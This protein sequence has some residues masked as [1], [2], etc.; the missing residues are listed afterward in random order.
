MVVSEGYAKTLEFR[1]NQ[2]QQ[3]LESINEL[4]VQLTQAQSTATRRKQT[5]ES[6]ETTMDILMSRH[7]V[8][9]GEQEMSCPDPEQACN[10]LKNLRMKL[11]EERVSISGK[12]G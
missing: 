2:S 1:Q 7:F 12:E 10:I 6:I 8:P 11:K 9:S 3:V 4:K 5:L